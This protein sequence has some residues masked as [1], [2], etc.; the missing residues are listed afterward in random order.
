MMC[1]PRHKESQYHETI[2]IL[3]NMVSS[4]YYFSKYLKQNEDTK[5]FYNINEKKNLTIVK[6]II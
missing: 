5:K 2:T 6:Q 4:S 1:V 3:H